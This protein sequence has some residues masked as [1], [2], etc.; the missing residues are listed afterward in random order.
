MFNQLMSSIQ[1]DV[2]YTIYKVSIGLQL[3]PSIMQKGNMDFQGAPKTMATP[4]ESRA[5]GSSGPGVAPQKEVG[6]NDPCYCGSGKK[7]K[8]CHGQ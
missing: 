7:F 2:V 6:R 1:Q 3:A 8:K 4:V 5:A